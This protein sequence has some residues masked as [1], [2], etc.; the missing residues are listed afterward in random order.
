MN[1]VICGIRKPRRHCPGVQ[2]NICSLCCGTEREQSI[3]CPLDCEYLRDA[4]AHEKTPEF[5]PTTLP[6]QDIPITEEF[7]KTN[8]VLLAFMA[9]MLFEAA[10][11]NT[12]Y[13][14]WDVRE[15]MEALVKTYRTLQLGFY[16]ESR[17]DNL[18]A[19]SIASHVR[20]KVADL[21]EREFQESGMNSIRDAAILGVFVFLQRLEYS[22][23][24]GRKRSRAYIDFL[25]G[26]YNP[27]ETS[28]EEAV[29]RM[30][31]RII[32]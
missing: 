9:M 3:D 1:C 10:R 32:L 20:E 19:A 7:L 15:A 31:P 13:T 21:K 27:V 11:Q 2:G 17:P 12:A 4:H 18:Y 25:S 14:D 8:E 30:S 22:H 16:Y 6:N 28:E 24:N 23:N 5:D 29:D 26:F